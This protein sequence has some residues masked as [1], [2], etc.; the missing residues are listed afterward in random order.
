MSDYLYNYD[1]LHLILPGVFL[2]ELTYIMEC[3]KL[4]EPFSGVPA[5]RFVNDVVM[6]AI[7]YYRDFHN[8]ACTIYG[9][10]PVKEEK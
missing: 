9:S 5:C 3:Q 7:L 10:M 4:L 1:D 2:D 6:E 8:N